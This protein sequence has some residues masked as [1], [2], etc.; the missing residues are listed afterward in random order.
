MIPLYVLIAR[1]YGL[2]DSY[3]GM[4]LPFAINSTAVFIF[5]QYFLQLPSELFEAARIDGAGELRVLW[6]VALPLVR[7]ALLTGVLLTFIGPWNEFLWPFLITKEPTC[8]RSR[9]R[10]P[11]T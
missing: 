5:R 10:W 2:A 4:I 11:T 9:S 7:P 6:R 3:L 1:N 8:S